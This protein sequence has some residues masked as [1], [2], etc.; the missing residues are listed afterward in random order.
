MPSGSSPGGGDCHSNESNGT[1]ESSGA[2]RAPRGTA[3]TRTPTRSDHPAGV[4]PTL[5][6]REGKVPQKWKDAVITVLHKKS[7]KTECGNYRGTS[8]VSHADK[9]LLKVVARRL[10][11]YCE[12]KGLL[13]EEQCR[14]RPNRS[15][16]DMMFVVGR[17]QE[18]GR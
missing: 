13:P 9:V 8:L 1:R 3:E 2:G 10:S 4:P 11:A 17:L 18:I 16:T 5:I 6:W 15:T 12:A 14:F 7:D